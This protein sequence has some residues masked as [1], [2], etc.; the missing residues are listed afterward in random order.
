PYTT[1][2]RSCF[3]CSGLFFPLALGIWWKRANAAGAIA[4]MVVGFGAGS[5]YLFHVYTGGAPW[6]GLE[7]I[8]FGMI[9]MPASLIAMV[10]VTL[11]TPAP[12]KEIQDMVDETR[13]PGGGPIIEAH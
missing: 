4:G 10:V 7:H 2:F 5:W 6:F 8:R 12:S 11:L 3:A 13:V 1:L 9:G